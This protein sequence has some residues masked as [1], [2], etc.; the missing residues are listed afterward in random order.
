MN[1]PINS[2]FLLSLD[3]W[4]HAVLHIV[5]R[6]DFLCRYRWCVI[7]TTP[8]LLEVEVHCVDFD[9]ET[10]TWG[11]ARRL[12]YFGIGA[13]HK[14]DPLEEAEFEQLLLD[15]QADMERRNQSKREDNGIPF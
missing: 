11:V 10:K 1:I 9:N 5:G 13:I 14:I 6:Q 4:K 2:A 7:G 3:D 15:L 12:D 8:V